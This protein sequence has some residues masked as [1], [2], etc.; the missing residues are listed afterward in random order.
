MFVITGHPGL[1]DRSASPTAFKSRDSVPHHLSPGSSSSPQ[2]FGIAAILPLGVLIALIALVIAV[3]IGIATALYISE[4]APL[5]LRR[6][7]I[8]LID[9]MAAIPSIIFGSGGCSS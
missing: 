8:A 2:H 3:P 5:R 1:P 9:L 6:P 7:L 4:Y